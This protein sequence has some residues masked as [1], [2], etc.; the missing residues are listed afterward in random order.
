VEV[1]LTPG[2]VR[3]IIMHNDFPLVADAS[4]PGGVRAAPASGP[5]ARRVG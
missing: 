3:E 4:A 5:A 2:E 1:T